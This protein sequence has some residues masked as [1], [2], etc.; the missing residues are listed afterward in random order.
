MDS[1]IEEPQVTNIATLERFCVA[2]SAATVEKEINYSLLA[3]RF[4]GICVMFAATAAVAQIYPAKA[5]R[6][7]VPFPPGGNIDI[8]ARTI[9]PGLSESLGQQV[10]VDNRGGAGGIIGAELV[11]KAA[12]DGYNLVLGSSG[13]ITIAPTLYAKAPYTLDSFTAICP[14]ANAPLVLEIHPSIPAKSVQQFIALARSRPERM[15]MASSGNGT[16]NHLAG[17]LFQMDTGVHFSHIPYKGSGLA[18][19]ELIAGQVELMFDQLSSSSSFLRSG[20]LRGLAVTT[21]NRTQLFPELPTLAE[22]GVKGYEASTFAGIMGPAGM[23]RE[24]VDKLN[25]AAMKVLAQSATRERFASIGS[26]VL[27]GTPDQFEEFLKRDYAK[28]SRVIK[29]AKVKIE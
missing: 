19:V 17:E 9:A 8:T 2:P 10:V 28:W 16:T 6:L 7:I 18:L 23:P 14:V 12:P 20:K 27:G 15:T 25:A 5:V 26:D 13:T 22:A 4:A 3:R 24:I 11:A 29:Q 21:A 1:I